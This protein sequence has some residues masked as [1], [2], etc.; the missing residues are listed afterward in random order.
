MIFN[1]QNCSIHDGSG[2]RTLVFFKG[3]PLHCLWCANPESQSCQPD[4]MEL[5]S[6][7]I[8]CGAC[9][10]VCPESAIAGAS[11]EFRINRDLCKLCFKCTNRCYA[12]SKRVIGR[13]YS[14]E[15]L[16]A[17][18]A[19][20]RPFYS[21]YGGGVT[22][23]GGEPLTQ[24]EFLA[25]IAKRCHGSGI[26]VTVESCGYA[27][28]DQFK[29]A[30]PYIGDMFLDIKHIDTDVHKTLTGKG[31]ELIL[32]NIKRISDYGIPITVRTPVIPGYNDSPQNIIGIAEFIS[33]L[34]SVKEYELLP[35]HNFG[36]SKYKSLGMPYVIK[37]VLSPLDSNMRDLVK[38][39]NQILQHCGKECFY[40]KDNNKEIVK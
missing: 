17:R 24:P 1:I 32:D 30:L 12:E 4:I 5:P 31:N 36:E 33:A 10:E 35:Y 6:R 7:C 16:F 14:V 27:I 40:I 19:K 13:E 21:M 26:H 29:A 37:G 20:D 9:E 38:Q 34:P 2:L 28:Y 25:K 8:G 15:E 23:S 18:I 39:A 11:G 22:F 3:C